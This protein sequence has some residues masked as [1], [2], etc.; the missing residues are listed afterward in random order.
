MGL[1]TRCT[2]L[3]DSNLATGPRSRCLDGPARPI[4]LRI[5]LAEQR[6]HMLRA[7]CGPGREETMPMQ[8]KRTAT[9]DR[10]E[11]IVSHRISRHT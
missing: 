9:M 7:L 10:F 3:A 4:V 8:V 5:V 6:Q 1:Q 11:A 2:R